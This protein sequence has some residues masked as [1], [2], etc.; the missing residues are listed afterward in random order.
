[1]TYACR[2]RHVSPETLQVR[3]LGEQLIEANVSSIVV[4]MP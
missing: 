2:R 4:W 3:A 1:M